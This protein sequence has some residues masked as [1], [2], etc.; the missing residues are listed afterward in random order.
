MARSPT[1]SC[2]CF[3]LF[4]LVACRANQG[5]HAEP[6]PEP[7]APRAQ[8]ERPAQVHVELSLVE[9]S[10]RE[11]LRA[12]LG[13]GSPLAEAEALLAVHHQIA[14]VSETL[15]GLLQDQPRQ[16]VV[17]GNQDAHAGVPL[18]REGHRNSRPNC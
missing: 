15:D 10:A 16:G 7:E 17:F 12:R 9:A 8:V 4:A 14:G 3:A 6:E 13:P 5:T 11:E 18:V 1:A 2:A